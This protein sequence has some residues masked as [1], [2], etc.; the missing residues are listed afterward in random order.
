M[1]EKRGQIQTQHEECQLHHCY[2]LWSYCTWK[3]IVPTEL[4]QIYS[5]LKVFVFLQSLNNFADIF[6]K[7]PTN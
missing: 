3:T 4:Q 1:V 7:V 6:G 5:S 2:A